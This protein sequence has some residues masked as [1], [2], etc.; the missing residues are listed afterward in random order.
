MDAGGI[1]L[2]CGTDTGMYR[3]RNEDCV[4]IIPSVNLA[5]LADG[6]GGHA[7][8]DIAS[9]TA[10]DTA[11]AYITSTG[12][13][14][15]TGVAQNIVTPEKLRNALSN[16]NFAI[17]QKAM[18][19]PALQDMGC[20]MIAAIFS[21]QIM[22]A[23][24]IGDSRLYRLRQ[25]VLEQISEDHTMAREYMR[26][27]MISEDDMMTAPG[28]NTLIRALGIEEE[29]DPDI[30]RIAVNQGDR[31]LLCS[32]GLTDAI[33]DYY[34][35]QFLS[36]QTGSPEESINKLIDAANDNGGPDNIAV[37]IAHIG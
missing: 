32:D 16:A 13:F 37:I 5:I 31:Y 27:G 10:V 2:A 34:I 8:G 11:T 1:Q 19:D 35:E 3:L 12:D 9:R 15:K 30:I 28:R 4:R 7:A 17:R 6:M 25:G 36:P 18:T 21:P 26:I 23:A 14:A 33:G 24:H 29:V 20:T 22:L